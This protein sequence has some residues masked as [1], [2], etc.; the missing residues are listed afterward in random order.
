MTRRHAVA[1]FAAACHLALVV[2]GAAGWVFA[3]NPNKDGPVRKTVRLY[4]ALS[5]AD[6]AYG[7]FAPGV[8]PQVRATF[9]LSDGSGR[10]WTDTLERGMSQ[11]AVHRAGGS[12]ALAA[13]PAYRDDLIRSWAGTMFGRHPDAR[14]VVVRLQLFDPPS[15]AEHEQGVRA[16]WETFDE[17][18]CDRE[19]QAP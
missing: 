7:Y 8:G 11:E 9:T 17:V 16:R 6:N 5:G 13:E 3:T 1:T 18:V 12:P 4:G 2:C 14:R 19:D 10:T 15:M